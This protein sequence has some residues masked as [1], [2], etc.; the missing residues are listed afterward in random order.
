VGKITIGREGMTKKPSLFTR[1]DSPVKVTAAIF[2]LVVSAVGTGLGVKIGLDFHY[3][4]AAEVRKNESE[5]KQ[6]FDSLQR[7][8]SKKDLRELKRERGE[9]ERAKETRGL[10]G[11]EKGRLKEINDEIEALDKELNPVKK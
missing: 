1:L 2:A 3:A 8:L 6:K 10:S 9:V 5:T 11:Y 4:S 7:F